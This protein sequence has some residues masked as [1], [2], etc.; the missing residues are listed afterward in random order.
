SDVEALPELYR[1]LI[2]ETTN[3]VPALWRGEFMKTVAAAEYAGVPVDAA[4][5]RRMVGQ[6][7]ALPS[8]VSYPVNEIFPVFENGHFRAALFEAWLR[9]ERLLANWPVTPTGEL[10]LDEDTFRDA[11]VRCPQVEPLR[12]ARQLLGQMRKPDLSIGVD[13]R[14]RCLLS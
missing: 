6:W 4:L 3:L 13:G 1:R 14:N 12:Q 2:G 7:P 5:Y 10:A 8:S 9:D 11:A